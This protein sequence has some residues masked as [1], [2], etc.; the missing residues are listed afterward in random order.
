MS[1]G[2]DGQFLSLSGTSVAVPFVTGAIALLWSQFPSLSAAQ[3]KLALTQSSSSRRASVL[4]PLLDVEA[5][6]QILLASFA[7]RPMPGMA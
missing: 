2:S 1:L 5:T 4:P 3:I 7:A 6:Y